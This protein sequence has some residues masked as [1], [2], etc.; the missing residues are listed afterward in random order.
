MTIR[1]GCAALLLGVVSALA[2]MTILTSRLYWIL[3]TVGV[4]ALILA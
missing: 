3:A 2:L 4:L 1:P